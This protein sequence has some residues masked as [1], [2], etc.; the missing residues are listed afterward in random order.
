MDGTTPGTAFRLVGVALLSEEFGRLDV[1]LEAPADGTVPDPFDLPHGAVVTLAL[2]FRSA[3]DVDGLVYT[4]TRVHRGQVLSTTR[5][6]LG[7][8]RA[9]GPYEIRMPPERLPNGRAVG[10]TYEVTGTFSDAAGHE[11]ARERHRFRLC[12]SGRVPARPVQGAAPAA[13]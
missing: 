13:P 10:N 6:A 1:P 11:L 7:G 12:A 3:V 2:T 4:E 9:G 5:T 8:F